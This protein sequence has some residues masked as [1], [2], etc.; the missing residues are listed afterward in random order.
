MQWRPRISCLW[1]LMMKIVFFSFWI[2][3]NDITPVSRNWP[4]TQQ[5][6]LSCHN[7]KKVALI[8][9]MSDEAWW[10]FFFFFF[11][12]IA[13][14][15]PPFCGSPHSKFSLS[16]GQDNGA[17]RFKRTPVHTLPVP[18]SS[19]LNASSGSGRELILHSSGDSL[20]AV[21]YLF[22]TSEHAC[23]ANHIL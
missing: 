20:L 13:Y 18:N 10:S 4:F 5:I 6:I 23:T 8:T 14:Q 11:N 22:I 12:G 7:W 1:G 2:V 9:V 19:E 17:F 3:G 21:V 15:T 16:Q